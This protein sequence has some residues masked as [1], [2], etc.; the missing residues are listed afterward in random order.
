M[1]PSVLDKA[2][3]LRERI[4]AEGLDVRIELDGGVTLENLDRVAATDV[5]MIVAGSAVFGGGDPRGSTQKFV[6][7]LAELANVERTC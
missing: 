2:R 5:D 7:R 3:R 6:R 1:I 4:D